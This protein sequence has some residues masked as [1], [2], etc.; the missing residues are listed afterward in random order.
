MTA[1]TSLHIFTLL[2]TKGSSSKHGFIFPLPNVGYKGK[3]D[4]TVAYSFQFPTSLSLPSFTMVQIIR[5][6]Q[7]VPVHLRR[8]V[9]ASIILTFPT[10]AFSMV[11]FGELSLWIG[12]A[13]ILLTWIYHLVLI[14]KHNKSSISST[15]ELLWETKHALIWGYCLA[16]L[17]TGALVAVIVLM[18][19]IYYDADFQYLTAAW[20]ACGIL[21]AICTLAST[22]VMWA[23]MGVATHLKKTGGPRE[24][25]QKRP[26]PK[27]F[28]K[29]LEQREQSQAV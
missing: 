18:S 2:A 5:N 27:E 23:L 21:E 3:L 1:S 15:H 8:L 14:I 13:A 4:L 26:G 6:P 28:V 25:L 20:F 12:T 24:Y 9:Y 29:G 7:L 19:F 10:F 17:W 11:R 22:A 16:V